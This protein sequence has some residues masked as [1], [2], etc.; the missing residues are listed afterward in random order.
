MILLELSLIVRQQ[1]FDRKKEICD[2]S[3]I[4][5]QR[6]GMPQ[7]GKNIPKISH[8]NRIKCQSLVPCYILYARCHIIGNKK[9]N[10]RAHARSRTVK[11]SH[12]FQIRYRLY[13]LNGKRSFKMCADILPIEGRR[14]RHTLYFPNRL[15]CL[16]LW[17]LCGNPFDVTKKSV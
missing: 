4:C 9:T 14:H 1:M 12:H 15:E 17:H 5:W 10:E 16:V 7:Q 6:N 8:I 11:W 13:Y 2:W 3:S